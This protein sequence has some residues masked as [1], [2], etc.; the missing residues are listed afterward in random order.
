MSFLHIHFKIEIFPTHKEAE[1]AN[2]TNTIIFMERENK[3]EKI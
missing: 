3:N 1:I 2:I